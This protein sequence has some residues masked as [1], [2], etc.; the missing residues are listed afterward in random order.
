M[1]FRSNLAL[2]VGVASGAR[3]IG[4]PCNTI[5]ATREGT[6]STATSGDLVLG[7]GL[8]ITEGGAD[9]SDVIG[10]RFLD[11][12][13]FGVV[14]AGAGVRMRDNSGSG[15]RYGVGAYGAGERDIDASNAIDGDEPPPAAAATARGELAVGG[16]TGP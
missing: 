3:A 13:R 1:L 15:N 11:N 2:G 4:V 14:V 8:S 7:D 5:Q 16:V 12:E 10:N 9:P 6:L